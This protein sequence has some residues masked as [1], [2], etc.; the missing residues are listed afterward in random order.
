[1]PS[2]LAPILR[3]LPG[4][5]RSPVATGATESRLTARRIAE[6]L[7]RAMTLGRWDHAERIA[8]TALRLEE[9]GPQ[10]CERLARLALAR[11]RPEDALGII[12]GSPTR[13]A[14]LRLLRNACLVQLG[15]AGQARRDLRA[16]SRES[17]APN[18]A[19]L[20]LALL[21][22]EHGDAHAA[23]LTAL[24]NLRQLED[25]HTL[26]LLLLIA[27]AQ[28]R[29][30]HARAWG[31]RLA[32]RT[33]FGESEACAPVL[34]RSLGLPEVS[35]TA[36][37]AEQIELLALELTAAEPVIPA[38]VEAQRQRPHRD[39][40]GLLRSAIELALPEIADRTRAVEALATLAGL[41]GD[42]V[43]A[44]HWI[45]TGLELSPMSASLARLEI[46]LSATEATG[47]IDRGRIDREHAA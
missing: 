22:W 4:H 26:E 13:T 10:L 41:A 14:S 39:V 20:M 28:G 11:G 19:R 45:R 40:I 33:A 18:D 8:R 46:E 30:E 44:R 24:Q 16:W 15:G 6:S 23:T 29:G 38:L 27:V 9:K 17:S 7:D 31:D 5:G 32:A 21:D 25:P 42:L 43:T 2:I 37:S 3:L 35:E 34:R 36:A 12:D 47:G 1:M